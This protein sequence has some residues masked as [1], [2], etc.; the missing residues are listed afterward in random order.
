MRAQAHTG[1]T[2][3]GSILLGSAD[4]DRLKAW[5]RAALA[6]RENADGFLEFGGIDVLIDGRDD[7]STTSSEPGR[8]ILN[9]HVDDAHAAARR[10]NELGVSWLAEVEERDDGLFG[11]LLD[12]DGNYI[13]I[14]QLNEEF[15]AR[16]AMQTH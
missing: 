11:T 5:Y 13:Q 4:P 15:L 7:V 3:L 16:K 10:L 14:I 2:S 1:G 6:A 12:P 8:M 9:F